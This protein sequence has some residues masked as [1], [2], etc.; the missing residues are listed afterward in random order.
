MVAGR[1]SNRG[2]KQVAAREI[3]RLYV[4]NLTGYV[5]CGMDSS[6]DTQHAIRSSQA[7][8][9]AVTMTIIV[10]LYAAFYRSSFPCRL[11][12]PSS[13][14]HDVS[15]VSRCRWC[16]EVGI[17]CR[18][19]PPT[20]SLSPRSISLFRPGCRGVRSINTIAHREAKG[21]TSSRHC[22]RISFEEE[23]TKPHTMDHATFQRELG[24]LKQRVAE[25][26]AAYAR[27][28]SAFE[29]AKLRDEHVSATQ[30]PF[31]NTAC[32][33]RCICLGAPAANAVSPS[34]IC[35]AQAHQHFSLPSPPLFW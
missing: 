15:E 11:T 18:I 10:R 29:Y 31:V 2:V 14:V 22:S 20:A 4:H 16:V 9:A 12:S 30:H 32:D 3:Q 23:H 34:P 6:E 5:R 13:P 19:T 25:M 21:C 24:Q 28:Q 17:G 8:A 35:L 33:P 1:A 26:S 7:A 27:R